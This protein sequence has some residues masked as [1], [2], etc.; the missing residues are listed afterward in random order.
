MMM[1]YQLLNKW[2]GARTVHFAKLPISLTG[3]Y[4][5]KS[6]KQILNTEYWILHKDNREI[7]LRK[8]DGI[9]CWVVG[10]DN[11]GCSIWRPVPENFTEENIRKQI[12]EYNGE[13]I[14]FIL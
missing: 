14:Q 9:W 1:C 11:A 7:K 6:I 3:N 4:I 8:R 10:K 13:R 2:N 5:S 12:K